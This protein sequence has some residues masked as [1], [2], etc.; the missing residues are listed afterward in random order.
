MHRL[1]C[2]IMFM[3]KKISY[4]KYLIYAKSTGNS[5][6]AIFFIHGNS[7][8]YQSLDLQMLDKSLSS[9]YMLVSFDL[10]G[11][12]YSDWFSEESHLYSPKEFAK[13]TETVIQS[14]EVEEYIIVG[15]S[16]GTNI[17]GEIPKPLNGCKGIVLG[18]SCILGNDA[19]PTDVFK[20]INAPLVTLMSSP[21][22]DDIKKFSSLITFKDKTIQKGYFETYKKTDPVF[23]EELGKVIAAGEWSDELKNIGNQQIPVLVI[24][25]KEDSMINIHYLDNWAVLWNQKTHLIND[26]GHLVNQEKAQ[27]FND[28]IFSFAN[29]VF[30]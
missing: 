1:S 10:P 13:V 16:Y 28:L 18:G 6:K 15:I 23:R 12:G 21:S 19:T 20:E 26:A 29:S 22:E 24:F 30:K 11:H 2:Q 3:E 14:F 8:S 27:E 25:G 17:I 7:Q 9:K 5:N 4:G